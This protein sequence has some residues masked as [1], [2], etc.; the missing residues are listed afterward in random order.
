MKYFISG[1]N[2]N[3]IKRLHMK[4]DSVLDYLFKIVVA[5]I[6]FWVVCSLLKKLED[7]L[8]KNNKENDTIKLIWVIFHYL[9][10]IFTI[11]FIITQLI[12]VEISAA[13]LP[14]PSDFTEWIHGGKNTV[15][16]SLLKITIALLIYLII[17]GVLS[18]IILILQNKLDEKNVD[19]KLVM[20][21]P[22]I[23]KYILLT[24]II[25]A[26]IVQ[27]II[28]DI[29]SIPALVVYACICVGISVPETIKNATTFTDNKFANSLIN[30][31]YK[32]IGVMIVF[33]IVLAAYQGVVKFLDS[34]ARAQDITEC[35][36]SKKKSIEKKLGTEFTTDVTDKI[37]LF[38]NQPDDIT[39]KS[40]GTLNLIYLKG[41]RI[42]INT[43][44][45][46]YKF[47]NIAVKQPEVTALKET[48]YSYEDYAQAID[49]R[50]DGSK[51]YYYY[52]SK[53][54]DCLVLSVS[55]I[56]NRI[57]E[58]TYYSDYSK[59]K[60]LFSTPE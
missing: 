39:I 23:I 25:F 4:S 41:K 37:H 50:L 45:N 16:N 31:G 22:G 26:S 7:I 33:I 53:N 49:T 46:K 42:G 19:E 20:I 5:L 55:S 57:T 27:L 28:V 21:F 58:I 38:N 1:I 15:I 3:I 44:S 18:K 52:N 9:I 56:S 32:A 6:V 47:Y 36:T 10:I 29:N 48:T 14:G 51:T 17:N 24:F 43:S 8:L 13:A 35:L 40:D 11:F 59:I 54:N 2:L 30:F 60:N 12:V 34:G